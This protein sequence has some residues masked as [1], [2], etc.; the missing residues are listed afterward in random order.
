MELQFPEGTQGFHMNRQPQQLARQSR[1]QRAHGL[2]IEEKVWR[3]YMT[4]QRQVAIAAQLGVCPSRV[5]RYISRRLESI[6]QAAPRTGEE[7]AAM[8]E[9][10][11]AKLWRVVEETHARP[12]IVEDAT[13]E[14][15]IIE[16]TP[17]PQMLAV[18]LK[19]LEQLS[20]IY[21]LAMPVVQRNDAAQPY[22]KPSEIAERV[23]AM[24]LEKHGRS[25]LG[26]G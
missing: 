5:C 6:E 3:L 14:K 17:T 11:A 22:S 15:D 4:G 19:S 13:D 18:R 10:I 7:F 26:T 23:Q 9:Q 16:L 20:R 8:R 21:G 12:G 1:R 25:E 24:I 2:E